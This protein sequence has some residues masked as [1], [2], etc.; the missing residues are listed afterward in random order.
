MVMENILQVKGLNKQG[1]GII[2]KSVMIDSNLSIE[3]KAIYAYFQSYAGAGCAGF[4]SVSLVCEDLQIS[5]QRFHRH[6]L[7]LLKNNYISKSNI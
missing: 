5:T 2:P 3:A 4:P 7:Q 1:F 6:F